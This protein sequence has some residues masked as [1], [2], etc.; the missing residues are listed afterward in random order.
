[1]LNDYRILPKT[2]PKQLVVFLHG[3]GANGQDLL[4]LGN[5]WQK[6]LPECA[7][8][9]PDGSQVYDMAPFGRQ[10]FSL[11][12]RSS[13]AILDGA[14]KTRPV[15]DSY[16][17]T[18]L[19]EFSLPTRKMALV[20]FSQGTMMSLYLAPRRTEPLA[21]IM[22]YSGMLLG[23]ETLHQDIRSK[24]SVCLVHGLDDTVVPASSSRLAQQVL[25]KEG[26]ETELHLRDHL[27]H[28]ID[29]AGLAIGAA[30]LQRVF[31]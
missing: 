14:E 22:G 7:F 11:Q 9:S 20:G 29:D 27:G 15:L 4:G 3:V 1:M 21:G 8:I 17:D 26:I 5:E 6:A 19:T 10:W 23:G 31:G 18:L 16:L 25:R 30:F 28:G 24:P 13:A 12:D 2:A